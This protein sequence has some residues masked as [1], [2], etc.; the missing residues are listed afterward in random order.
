L[1]LS[2]INTFRMSFPPQFRRPLETASLVDVDL[3]AA[4]ALVHT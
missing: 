2:K 4:M 3:I 1:L